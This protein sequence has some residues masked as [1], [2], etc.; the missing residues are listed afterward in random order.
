MKKLLIIVVLLQIMSAAE[1]YKGFGLQ[2]G[3]QGAGIFYRQNLEIKMMP[4]NG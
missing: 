1:G 4:Y 2:V 3:E